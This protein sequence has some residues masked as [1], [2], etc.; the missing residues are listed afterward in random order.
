MQCSESVPF[1]DLVTLHRGITYSGADECDS[2][3]YDALPVIGIPSIQE[4]LDLTRVTCIRSRQRDIAPF[5][6]ERG[7]IVLVG[8]N[9]NPDRIG[10]P[11]Y[12]D[13]DG[14]FVFGAFVMMA[15]AIPG[16]DWK[17]LFPLLSG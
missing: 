7:D 3:E 1:A 14:T 11:A 8:S 4:R 12:F 10:N 2:A 17:Y 13:E 16:A 5:K 6:L 9:G 15:R